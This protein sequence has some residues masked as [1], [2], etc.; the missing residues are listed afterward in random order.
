[1][2]YGSHVKHAYSRV[3]LVCS[4]LSEMKP[5]LRGNDVRLVVVVGYPSVRLISKIIVI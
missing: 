5:L 2:P 4:L 1:M 3:H